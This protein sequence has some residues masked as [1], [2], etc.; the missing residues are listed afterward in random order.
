MTR[1]ST[2]QQDR[3]LVIHEKLLAAVDQ[4]CS[5]EAW[6]QMLGVAARFHSYSPN[7]VLLIAAQRPD[8][9]RIA[10][11]RAWTQLGRQ[12]RRGENGTAIL[13]PVLRRT[14]PAEPDRPPADWDEPANPSRVLRGFRGTQ[15][16][17]ISQ[18][19]GPAL[20]EV[21]PELLDGAAPLRLWAD[22]LDQVE[23]A[24]YTVT[25]S[26][27]APANG[28]TDFTD[29]SVTLHH[30]LPGAQLVKTLAHELAHVRL[31]APN[32]RPTG[33]D[34]PRAEVEAESVAYVVT[35]AHGLAAGDYSVP[36]V[37]GWASGDRD[38]IAS[39]ATRVLTCA[40]SMLRHDDPTVAAGIP[41]IGRAVDRDRI[42]AL[43]R[44][45]PELPPPA[46]AVQR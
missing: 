45:E 37:T 25:S 15:V 21:R 35:T 8:A 31:H 43:S 11:H 42:P 16:F 27:L 13:A 9:T 29:R 36:Y 2:S 30:D 22:L 38:L 34:R 44:P 46:R 39:A 32:V 17:D 12:V 7:N 23:A 19:D 14:K 24:G 33:L 20:P 4:L 6:R 1:P 10:G 26:D 40:R 3:L 5:S 28:R 41:A 18:T